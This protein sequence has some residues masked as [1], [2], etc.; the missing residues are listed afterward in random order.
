MAGVSNGAFRH[1]TRQTFSDTEHDPRIHP[2]K[3]Y[4][5]AGILV[6]YYQG[7]PSSARFSSLLDRP[8]GATQ[9]NAAGAG[10]GQAQS[11]TSLLEYADPDTLQ[12]HDHQFLRGFSLSNDRNP[13]KQAEA[14][15]RSHSDSITPASNHTEELPPSG[16]VN[17]YRQRVEAM[18]LEHQN[19]L[20]DIIA[21]PYSSPFSASSPELAS[22]G[23]HSGSFFTGQWLQDPPDLENLKPLTAGAL[24]ASLNQPPE[25]VLNAFKAKVTA[26]RQTKEKAKKEGRTDA[27]AE[28]EAAAAA[29]RIKISEPNKTAFLQ[30]VLDDFHEKNAQLFRQ[31]KN[32]R[33][34]DGLVL[35]I[36]GFGNIRKPQ[37]FWFVN[38]CL[39]NTDL[40]DGKGWST[41]HISATTCLG[42]QGTAQFPAPDIKGE[43]PRWKERTFFTA[44]VVSWIAAVLAAAKPLPGIS[45]FFMN[46]GLR[47]TWGTPVA[48]ILAGIGS[49]ASIFFYYSNNKRISEL[50]LNA[51]LKNTPLET[52]QR[53]HQSKTN[54]S[55]PPYKKTVWANCADAALGFGYSIGNL[56]LVIATNFPPYLGGLGPILRPFFLGGVF[57]TNFQVGT[58]KSS[59]LTQDWAALLERLFGTRNPALASEKKLLDNA[60]KNLSAAL[61]QYS[62]KRVALEK[63]K[64]TAYEKELATEIY[65]S[66]KTDINAYIC[67]LRDLGER[68]EYP[69]NHLLKDIAGTIA[70]LDAEFAYMDQQMLLIPRS[71]NIDPPTASIS[72][73]SIST[74]STSTVSTLEQGGK[75]HTTPSKPKSRKTLPQIV[76]VKQEPNHQTPLLPANSAAAPRMPEA[77]A[78]PTKDAR[79]KKFSHSAVFVGVNGKWPYLRECL[80]VILSVSLSVAGGFSNIS[81]NYDFWT[82]ISS[83]ALRLA[84]SIFCTLAVFGL[85]KETFDAHIDFVRKELGH[86][87]FTVSYEKITPKPLWQRVINEM[88]EKPAL[89]I[90][91]LVSFLQGSS[92]WYY[93]ASS[94]LLDP[95]SRGIAGFVTAYS[96]TTTKIDATYKLGEHYWKLFSKKLKNYCGAQN[97]D[98]PTITTHS[99]I[100]KFYDEQIQ[101]LVQEIC[102]LVDQRNRKLSL[103]STLPGDIPGPSR[104]TTAKKWFRDFASNQLNMKLSVP[105]ELQK[106]LE[107][108]PIDIRHKNEDLQQPSFQVD[109]DRAIT[110][111]QRTLRELAILTHPGDDQAQEQFYAERIRPLEHKV[112]YR[113]HQRLSTEMQEM[114]LGLQ[115]YNP[116]DKQGCPLSRIGST[117]PPDPFKQHYLSEEGLSKRSKRALAERGELHH[118]RSAQPS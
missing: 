54:L 71:Q 77:D 48:W 102:A 79:L 108:N 67:D 82:V 34:F 28:A 39:Q 107:L 84:W 36:E 105:P 109:A 55:I 83:N 92:G 1:Q 57:L 88:R 86:P 100:T 14:A 81:G 12:R 97:T 21:V 23:N 13:Y 16:E 6:Y 95:F 58:N 19:S 22:L 10:V 80:V 50:F 96:M 112:L 111:A 61:S 17:T 25:E 89:P 27:E 64:R 93:C 98:T 75:D 20:P 29:E 87:S 78:L 37:Q 90:A 7:T 106:K 66:I 51:V 70:D 110:V 115:A 11:T 30:W 60:L 4:Q 117:M 41:A 103:K 91:T 40:F 62:E 99:L 45:S 94:P 18:K 3:F 114:D 65:E 31:D 8:S 47:G 32:N 2:G 46:L 85:N 118:R 24:E 74:V 42:E 33:L 53:R 116:G 59:Q 43:L 35:R 44:K 73:A 76:R 5:D 68:P 52:I 38:G 72:T 15:A 101:I 63:I 69:L 56:G 104:A 49:A 113:L 26:R 9:S